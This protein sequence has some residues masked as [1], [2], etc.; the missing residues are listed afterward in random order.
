MK[1]EINDNLVEITPESESESR[2]LNTLWN[3][4]VDCVKFNKKLVPVGEYMPPRSNTAH[5]AIED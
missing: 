1:I 5:F 4:V 2:S 3:T